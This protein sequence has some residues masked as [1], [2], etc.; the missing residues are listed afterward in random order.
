[1]AMAMKVSLANI[2]SQSCRT[3]SQISQDKRDLF[4]LTFYFLIYKLENQS[5]KAYP[6]W[7]LN[8]AFYFRQ[9]VSMEMTS[10]KVK[11]IPT[12]GELTTCFTSQIHTF[13]FILQNVI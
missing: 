12:R 4:H 1:M 2:M 7:F 10:R 8:M 9:T 11:K 3:P 5:V 6:Y 13:V